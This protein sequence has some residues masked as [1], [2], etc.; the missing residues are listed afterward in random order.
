MW[1][2][3][4]TT[5]SAR[6]LREQASINQH[7]SQFTQFGERWAR[8]DTDL[9]RRSVWLTEVGTRRLEVALPIWGQAHAS[10]AD[11][12]KPH[13]VSDRATAAET[14]LHE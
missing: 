12:M 1:P 10:L 8:I 4:W 2:P 14:L 6:S 3:P 13:P 7:F 11:L 9:R 5:L